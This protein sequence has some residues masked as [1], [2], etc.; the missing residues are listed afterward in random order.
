MP[1]GIS[2]HVPSRTVDESMRYFVVAKREGVGRGIKLHIDGTTVEL[3]GDA[4]SAFM[5]HFYGYMSNHDMDDYR[6][7]HNLKYPVA[8]EFTD[9]FLGQELVAI[10]EFVDQHNLR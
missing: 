1:Q 10:K 4:W 3:S 8:Y 7:G 5:T 6:E 2:E 9:Y